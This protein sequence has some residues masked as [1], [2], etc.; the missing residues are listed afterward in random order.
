MS[1]DI[2]GTSISIVNGTVVALQGNAV[3]SQSL[4]SNQDGYA[5]TWVNGNNDWEAQPLPASLPPDGAA[6]GDL[7][8][9]YPNPTVAKIQGTAIST[10]VPND[11][12]VLTYVAADSEWEP[13]LPN[14]NNKVSSLK[15]ANYTVLTSDF[16]VGIGTLT[17]SITITLPASPNTG[18]MYIIKDVNGTVNQYNITISPASGNID[19]V[20]SVKLT[21]SYQSIT[22]V[23]TNS[24][25]SII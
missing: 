2:T 24:Q 4:G 19:G 5:L 1:S 12:Y 22:L 3:K 25:W 7:S 15:T 21:A 6:G 23:Y 13:K 8:G 9:N 11:G 17:S 14:H 16:I 10:T 18:D 20:S